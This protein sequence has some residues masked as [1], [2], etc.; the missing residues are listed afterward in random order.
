MAPLTDPLT[1]VGVPSAPIA[2]AAMR[3]SIANQRS[4]I[5]NQSS[6]MRSLDPQYFTGP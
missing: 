2:D 3:V 1:L 6:M 4:S 5:V